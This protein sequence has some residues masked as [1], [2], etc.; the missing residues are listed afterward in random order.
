MSNLRDTIHQKKLTR[1]EMVRRI[2]N[3]E[4]TVKEA[5]R[6]ARTVQDLEWFIEDAE[7]HLR[8][9]QNEDLRCSG[10]SNP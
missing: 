2:E 10:G 1:D 3:K 7:I 4:C 9:I 5:E 6:Y 8:E